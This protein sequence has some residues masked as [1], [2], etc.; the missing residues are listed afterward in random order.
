VA[1]KKVLTITGKRGIGCSLIKTLWKEYDKINVL[2]LH[3]LNEEIDH[4]YLFDDKVTHYRCDLSSY[5]QVTNIL[6]E[7]KL[8]DTTCLINN[9]GQLHRFNVTAFNNTL[10]G[11]MNQ[12]NFVSA[13]RLTEGLLETGKLKHIVN[14][15]SSSA[16]H[17]RPREIGY[18]STQAA[19]L[20][21]S[22]ALRDELRTRKILVQTVIPGRTNTELRR[23]NFP[24]DNPENLMHPA[25][26]AEV[27]KTY[28]HSGDNAA[29]YLRKVGDQI[30]TKRLFT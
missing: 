6:E 27:I 25:G 11:S 16:L 3:N 30:R 5:K 26:L 10:Y 12:I 13:V 18:S 9:A 21:W 8:N 1:T 4:T 19:K 20:N 24:N 23:K 17:G 7:G 14:I 22:I 28:M 2:S 15:T 29:L